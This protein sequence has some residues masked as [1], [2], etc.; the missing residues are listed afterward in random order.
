MNSTHGSVL[1]VDDSE[2][3]R[4]LLLRRLQRYGHMVTVAEDGQQA[5]KIVQTRSFDLIVLDIMMPVMN[6]YEV[7]QFLKADPGLRHIPVIIVS[8]VDD[9]D[10][11]VRCIELGAEDY[12]FKPFNPV[13]LKAR[14][15]AILEKKRLRDQEQAYLQ[16]VKQEMELGRRTQADFLPSVLPQSPGWDIAAAF[17]PAREVAGDFYDAFALSGNRLALVIADVCDKGV[18][19]A[20]FM[21]LIRTLIRAFAEQAAF[22][23][24]DALNSV[25][26]INNY[27]VRHHHQNKKHMFAT[28]FFGVLELD[29]GLLT[30]V[31][32]GHDAPILLNPAGVRALLEPTGPAVGLM[33][34]V[35]F[36]RK[37]A[38]FEPGDMLISYTDGVTEAR[39]AA[40]AFYTEERLLALLEQP[41]ASARAA[42][43]RVEASVRAHVAHSP[44]ADDLTMLAVRRAPAPPGL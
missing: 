31:N 17:Y 41:G 33:A 27:I 43:E 4:D 20:L 28:L 1:V 39:N 42:L 36:A 24:Y 7:L 5:L 10:S 30:Y 34:N 8:A 13:L 16:A 44:L 19:A 22:T 29:T 14:I 37:Q 38:Y 32:A 6:G 21:A 2:N 25:P 40:G 35:A 23:A 11:I 9:I 12:L 18:G 3:N 26:L 15:D